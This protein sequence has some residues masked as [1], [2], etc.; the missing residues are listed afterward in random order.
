MLD[1][2]RATSD[3]GGAMR[4]MLGSI[5]HRGPDQ[6]GLYLYASGALQVAL[7]HARLSII[8]ID[9]G[10]QPLGNRDGA[11]WIVFNGEVFNFRELRRDLEKLGHR[12]ATSTDT[13]VVLHL[14]ERY[15]AACLELLNGQ[16]ALAIWDESARRLFLARDP[17]G[18]L[19]LYYTWRNGQLLFASEIKALLA[20]PHVE[21]AID[22]IG[23]DQVF[24]YWGPLAPRTCFT[25]VRALPPGHRAT[26]SADGQMQV[27]R[28]WS[29]SFPG[30][31]DESRLDL[32]EAAEELH[33]L[34]D[35][36]T[37]IRLRADVTVGAYLSG[38]LDSSAVTALARR[39]VE[40]R[41]ETFSVAFADESF[42]ESK[43]QRA[44]ADFLGTRHRVVTC[45]SNDIGAVFPE[46]VWHAEAALL[47][48]APAPLFLLSR[49]VRDSGIKVVL[50]GEGSDEFL[51]GYNIFKEAKVRRF[52]ARQ[53]ES[54]WR[55]RLLERLYPYI[56]QL[57]AA[58]LPYLKSFFGQDLDASGP[59]FSHQVRW[60][61]TSRLKRI[62]SAEFRETIRNEFAT[63]GAG[64]EPSFI[65]PLVPPEFEGWSGLARAQFL[66]ATVFL[67]DYLLSSQGDRMLMAHGIEG[68]FPFLDPRVISFCNQ[69]S[70]HLKLCGLNEKFVLK[71][72]IGRELPTSVG[73]RTKRPFRAPIQAAF[74]RNGQWV[75]WAADLLSA[76]AIQSSGYFEPK[77]VAGLTHKAT[78]AQSLSEM[79][80]MALVGVI[81]TQLL[82]SMFVQRV[83]QPSN[84]HRVHEWKVV[85][86]SH[87]PSAA[88]QERFLQ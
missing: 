80:G 57:S 23:L 53:P 37:K 58:G 8:D 2:R 30:Q 31:G 34:L 72:A 43:F 18:I 13:E 87:E 26:V 7:A 1:P 29:L 67:P 77:A 22:P 17:Q 51:G 48:T 81:S 49:L 44:T 20:H 86:H 14:Y 71:Q 12:F 47:R 66:E 84:F 15:G 38:G 59:Y 46:V 73:E 24:S 85:D 41:L 88:T 5:Q 36:A 75:E 52:W 74:V 54:A 39:A 70:P 27:E 55:P 32:R 3:P 33:A 16:F 79:D 64:R 68:R 10:Q 9:G 82:H 35:D 69:L 78:R 45:D 6:C 40:E 11:K 63:S 42:D 76:P 19:P 65:G 61:G 83:R 62:F 50:T 21:A 56:P 4:R 25:D 28:Y 60:N